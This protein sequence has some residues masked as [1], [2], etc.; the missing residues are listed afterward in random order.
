LP[1]GKLS[2]RSGLEKSGQIDGMD[3]FL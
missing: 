2:G 1:D 3:D